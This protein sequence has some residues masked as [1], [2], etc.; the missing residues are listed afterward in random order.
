MFLQ[1]LCVYHLYCFMTVIVFSCHLFGCYALVDLCV[2]SCSSS[3]N[4]SLPTTA[5]CFAHGAT[6]SHFRWDTGTRSHLHLQSRKNPVRT[7][8]RGLGFG[9]EDD[10]AEAL[11]V[12]PLQRDVEA[13]GPRGLDGAAGSLGGG[14]DEGGGGDVLRLLTARLLLLVVI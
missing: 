13:V 7:S 8:R 12:S 10:K 14:A 5:A 2:S 1:I 9:R 6:G 11:V 3:V 4:T